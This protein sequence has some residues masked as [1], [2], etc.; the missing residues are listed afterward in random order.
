[1]N[2]ISINSITSDVFKV[3]SAENGRGDIVKAGRML[4]YQHACKGHNALNRA[5]GMT[6]GEIALMS[7]EDYKQLNERFQAEHLLYC[8]KI[9][10]DQVGA[11]AP[12]SFDAF[13]RQGMNYYRNQRFFAALAS[14]YQE[15][16]T[17]ILPVVYS[18]A[19]DIF[20]DTVEV[21]F[22][23]TAVITVESND[24]P[25]FQDSSWGASRSTP[26][27]YFYGRDIALNPQPRTATIAAKW[28][29]LVANGTD[30]GAFFANI[31]AG[32]YAKTMG[33]Y[34]ACMVVAMSDTSKI[35][36]GLTYNFSNANWV[37]LANKLSALNNVPVGDLIAF[38]GIVP[39]ARVLPTDATGTTNTAMDSVLAE[40]LGADYTR[41]GHFGEFMGVR[42]R[43]LIDA[44]VPGTQNSSISTVLPSNK[45]WMMSSR[46][47]KPLTIAWLADSPISLEVRPDVAGDAQL[48]INLTMAL[49]CAAVFASKVGVVTIA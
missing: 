10:C 5:K 21:G 3:N 26:R 25:I 45:I 7:H 29:Q 40:I 28:S 35:P 48:Q 11:T 42:L 15:I 27:N 31:T 8:A 41:T 32:M 22:G 9:A 44:I 34:N 38:G 39:L 6:G 19:V 14:L 1:M 16:I 43:A 37:A 13:K 17:P 20:A 4:A 47:R 49:D 24:I 23:E 30:F 46:G 36:S 12:E 2:R 33:L 18:D